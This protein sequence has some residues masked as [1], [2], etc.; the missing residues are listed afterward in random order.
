[1]NKN[2]I[3]FTIFD[4]QIF[5]ALY[6]LGS[7]TEVAKQLEINPSL[8]SIGLTRFEKKIG[9][10]K[11]F[12]KLS[13]TGK[14]TPTMNANKIIQYMK[15]VIQFAEQGLKQNSCADKNVII[16]ST[17]TILHYYLGDYVKDLIFDNPD[18][19]ID[20]KQ[21]ETV[22][23][24]NLGVN[25]I[26]LTFFVD[27][28]QNRK[29]FPYHTFKQKLWASPEYIEKFGEPTSY[30]DLK[31]HR[32]LLRKELD[33]PRVLFGSNYLR[34][35]LDENE[36]LHFYKIYSTSFIDKLCVDGCGIMAAAEE[37]IR[38]SKSKLQNVFP[39]FK[40]EEMDVYVC[41][42]KEFLQTDVCKKIVNWIFECRKNSFSKAGIESSFAFTPLR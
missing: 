18:L 10:G 28:I 12:T 36:H 9:I 15:Y 23:P 16:T 11:L 1:M 41:V 34:S 27:N 32:L 29:F 31:N 2:K 24:K 20:F 26:G 14:Y 8:V 7:T 4:A 17:H 39:D 5:C 19:Y 38:L 30:E 40:G 3:N 33:D 37:S 35:Q 22:D 21:S 13:K 6:D 42:D 25:E